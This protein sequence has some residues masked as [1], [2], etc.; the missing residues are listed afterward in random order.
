MTRGDIYKKLPAVYTSW[1]G[2]KMAPALDTASGNRRSFREAKAASETLDTLLGGDIVQGIMIQ[3]GRL[4]AV[5]DVATNENVTW[6]TAAH[7][8]IVSSDSIGLITARGR[9]NQAND[10]RE[11]MRLNGYVRGT[12]LSAAA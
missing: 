9:S 12:G 1:F 7:H 3:L 11:L 2:V 8:E 6:A 4:T 10:Q 5:T